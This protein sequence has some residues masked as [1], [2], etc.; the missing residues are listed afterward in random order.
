VGR[1]FGPEEITD[2]IETVVETYLAQRTN[3][4]ETFLQAYRR[5]G[6]APFKEALYGSEARAA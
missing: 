6:T 3:R 4:E 1:G 2:A 5:L